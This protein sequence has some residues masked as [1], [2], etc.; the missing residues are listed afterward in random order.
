MY[1]LKR[2]PRSHIYEHGRNQDFFGGGGVLPSVSFI[3]FLPASPFYFPFT[4]ALP[5][6]GKWPLKFS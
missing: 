4:A 5:F 3:P 6:D 2:N 1:K